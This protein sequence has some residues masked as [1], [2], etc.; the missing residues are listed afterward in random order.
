MISQK[1]QALVESLLLTVA[2]I[3]FFTLLL[4]MSYLMYAKEVVSYIHYRALFCTKELDKDIRFCSSWASNKI[5]ILLFFHKN[6]RT[7]LKTK[8]VKTTII[9][10][11]LFM[12][13]KMSSKKSID[14]EGP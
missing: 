2:L 1:G 12:G 11:G 4:S 13:N 3:P 7:K 14:V 6:L 5:E 9:T 10:S 8:G